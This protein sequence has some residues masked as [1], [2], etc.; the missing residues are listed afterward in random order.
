[1]K[2]NQTFPKQMK[3]SD[4]EQPEDEAEVL[5]A[6]VIRTNPR[7]GRASRLLLEKTGYCSSSAL[8]ERLSASSCPQGGD[9]TGSWTP[10]RKGCPEG[11]QSEDGR[12][13]VTALP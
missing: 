3:D 8:G 6:V 4:Q 7:H 9:A 12:A 2:A 11:Y 5:R 1:M 13:E 10:A